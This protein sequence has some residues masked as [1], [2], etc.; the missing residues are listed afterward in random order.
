MSYTITN[1]CIGCDRCYVQ[2]PTGAIQKVDGLLLIDSTLCND[3]VGYHGTPQCASICPTNGGCIPSAASI[4][5]EPTWV[6][7][8][9]KSEVSPYWDSWFARYNYL[10]QRLKS[11]DQTGYWQHWFDTYSSKLTS[12]LSQSMI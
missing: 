8:A 3:C 10:M 6:P 9:L 4:T 1:N 5:P 11:G 2:C 7:Q 12:L